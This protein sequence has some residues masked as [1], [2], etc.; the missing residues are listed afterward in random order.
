MNSSGVL[1]DKIPVARAGKNGQRMQRLP[2]QT[3]PELT[4]LNPDLQAV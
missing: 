1:S 4:D 2:A 3:A